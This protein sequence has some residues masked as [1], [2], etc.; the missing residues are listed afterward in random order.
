MSTQYKLNSFNPAFARDI[1][2]TGHG[3]MFD[4]Y[5]PELI[6]QA[7]ESNGG[8][9]PENII[10]S[11]TDSW[12]ALYAVYPLAEDEE[13]EECF[14]ALSALAGLEILLWAA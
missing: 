11:L 4:Y 8:E 10:I 3:I 14:F 6:R 9:T 7:K 13:P 1:D 2:Y 12:I 5:D